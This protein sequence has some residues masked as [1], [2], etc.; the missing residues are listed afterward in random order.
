MKRLTR[1]D[2]AA[3][4]ALRATRSIAVL[5]ASARAGDRTHAV[6]EYLRRSGYDVLPIRPDRRDV[7]GRS[8]RS[9]VRRGVG[10]DAA[11]WRRETRRWRRARRARRE[12]DAHRR[13]ATALPRTPVR[14]GRRTRISRR[15]VAAARRCATAP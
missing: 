12:E 2:L 3:E 1:D 11:R 4:R 15:A 14:R 6:V 8:G 13:R 7:A 9:G 5:G 10:V